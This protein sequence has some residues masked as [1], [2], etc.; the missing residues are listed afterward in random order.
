MFTSLLLLAQVYPVHEPHEP[1]VWA[2]ALGICLGLAVSL[3]ISAV[4][5]LLVYNAQKAI[6]AEHRKIEPGLIWLLLIPL[7]NLVW[8]FFVF[9]RVPESYRSYFA[10]IGRA[11][12][13]ETEK[14]L[15]LGYSICVVCTF[16]PCLGFF[17]GIAALVLLIIFLVKI[18]GL[19]REI[20]KA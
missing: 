3:V 9:M 7:F 1:P 15:G 19:K 6:P 12:V 4:I 5:S 14:K 2:G 18:Y 17:A 8:N 11:N 20:G 16:I 13:G 10:S